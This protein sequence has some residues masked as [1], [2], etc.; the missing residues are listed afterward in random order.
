MIYRAHFVLPMNGEPIQGGEVL[1]SGGLIE[2]V[3]ADLASSIPDEPVVDFGHAAIMPGFVNL[4]SHLDYTIFRGI[5]NGLR[6]FPWIR[7]L[8]E[9]AANLQYEDF[10][11]SARLGALQMAR[12]GVTT[13]GDSSFS[14]AAFEAVKEAGIGGVVYLETFGSDPSVDYSTQVDQLAEKIHQMNSDAGDVLSVGVSPH[15]VYTST[16]PLLLLVADMARDEGIHIALHLSETKEEVSFIK[17]ADGEIADFYSS[18]GFTVKPRGVTPAEYLHDLGILSNKTVLAHCV[19]ITDDDLSIIA[20]EG[21]RIAHCPKSNAKLGVGI[22]PLREMIQHGILTGLGTDSAASDDSL[23][24]FEE[25]RFAVLLQRGIYSDVLAIDAARILELATIGG[26]AALGLDTVI[27]SLEAGKRADFI[28]V[29]LSSTAAFPSEDPYSAIV[30]SC[31]ASD[32]LLTM[33]GGN[34]VYRN[35]EYS[36]VD[37]DEIK[38]QSALSAAK[39]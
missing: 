25:M 8:I 5:G 6:F 32:V 22:A 36:Q 38:R 14:G 13:I 17:T 23:D 21:A 37:A 10:L 3:G 27:G 12:S 35:G 24:M 15:S 33:I 11:A 7:R 9:T 30:Y 4:H 18:K 2:A 34:I 19:H 31:S 16:E 29:D 1:V 20:E 28:A 26:A 39:L